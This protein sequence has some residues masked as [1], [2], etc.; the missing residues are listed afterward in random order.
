MRRWPARTRAGR[1]GPP[2]RRDRSGRAPGRDLSARLARGVRRSGP[3][4]AVVASRSLHHIH[5]LPGGL[6]KLQRLLAPGGRLIVVEHAFDRFDEPTAALVPEKRRA[7][8]P[9]APSSVQACL[10][11]WEADHADLHGYTAMRRELD[12][13]FTERWFAWTP[14]LYLELGGARA[15]GAEADRGRLDHGH[16][17]P[18]CR[19]T[20]TVQTDHKALNL[21]QSVP[22]LSYRCRNAHSVRDD[23]RSGPGGQCVCCHVLSRAPGSQV[24]GAGRRARPC[25]VG[26]RRGCCGHP[27]RP[28]K[29]SASGSTAGPGPSAEALLRFSG[30]RASSRAMSA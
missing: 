15:G 17:L 2:G 21:A 1:T 19:R 29:Q 23:G 9:H 14:S 11:E 25:S 13:R 8:G 10:A 20:P 30:S 27:R 22:V 24:C 7:K 28:I 5:D 6:S 16:R 18:V 4:D 26:R 3:F 12:L